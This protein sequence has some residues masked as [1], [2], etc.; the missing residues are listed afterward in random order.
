MTKL[1]A[2]RQHSYS[3]RL[4]LLQF[5]SFGAVGMIAPYINLYL[6]DLEFSGVLIGTLAASAPFCLWHSRRCS[7][8]SLTDSCC[9]GVY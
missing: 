2:I 8:K 9:I 3:I 6:T 7:T 5:L 1:L 4:V